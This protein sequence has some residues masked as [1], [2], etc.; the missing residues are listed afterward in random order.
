MMEQNEPTSYRFLFVLYVKNVFLS[1][2]PQLAS[3]KIR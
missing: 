1:L 2:G 3:K